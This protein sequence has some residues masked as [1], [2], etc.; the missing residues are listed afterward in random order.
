MIFGPIVRIKT[1]SEYNNA[2]RSEDFFNRS[3]S[4]FILPFLYGM[5]NNLVGGEI[6]S[7]RDVAGHGCDWAGR[8]R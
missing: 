4:R 8:R 2:S 6:P 5:S 7:L 1:I 3:E